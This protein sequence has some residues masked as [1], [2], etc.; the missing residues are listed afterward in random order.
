M[1]PSA[2]QMSVPSV[3]H[4]GG[5][6]LHQRLTKLYS[7]TKQSYE[8]AAE[9][10]ASS[11]PPTATDPDVER[12]CRDFQ[13]QKDRLLA[14]GL[15]W[16]DTN[17]TEAKAS[18]GHE[19]V[20]IDKKL[21]QAGHG[22][23]VADVMSEIQR[24]LAETANM[25]QPR[26]VKRMKRDLKTATHPDTTNDR[27]WSYHEIKEFR[28][29][30]Q[31]LT[32][33]LDVLYSLS[34]S[35]R[36]SS[37]SSKLNREQV[38]D[39]ARSPKGSWDDLA[40]ARLRPQASLE[41]IAHLRQAGLLRDVPK[42]SQ[43]FDDIYFDLTTL[44]LHTSN[45]SSDDLPL[46]E[47]VM[48]HEKSRVLGAL[49]QP[50]KGKHLSVNFR[51]PN[52]LSVSR[53][54][55]DQ[56][57]GS[58]PVFIE[59]VSYAHDPSWAGKIGQGLVRTRHDFADLLPRIHLSHTGHLSFVGFTLD[60]STSRCG[61][62][63]SIQDPPLGYDACHHVVPKSLSSVLSSRTDGNDSIPN[64]EDRFRL[65]Y[66]LTIALASLHFNGKQHGN[67]D[68]TNVVLF[69]PSDQSSVGLSYIRYPYLFSH[70]ELF[71]DSD[72]FSGLL[73][74]SIYR[75]SD[76]TAEPPSGS[77]QR[78]D[79][80]DMSAAHEIYSLGL[81][82]LE[83]GLW[84]PLSKFWKSKY[85]NAVF[86]SRVKHL[87]VPKLASKCGST[88][89]R[90]VMRCLDVPEGCTTAR[91]GGDAVAYAQA[92]LSGLLK[93]MARCCA[94]DV[95]G[96]T[97]R[98]TED[99]AYFESKL[100]HAQPKSG[101]ESL[102]LDVPMTPQSLPDT[103]AQDEL[104]ENSPQLQ[105]APGSEPHSKLQRD[106]SQSHVLRRFPEKQ[107]LQEHI[108]LWHTFLMPRLSKL[109]EKSLARSSTSSISLEMVGR[110]PED[111]RPTVLIECSD[112][113]GVGDMLK[114][115]FKPKRGWGV[116]VIQGGIRRSGKRAS[117]K[118]I[119]NQQSL[120]SAHA[121]PYK[122]TSYQAIPG[123]GASIGAFVNHHHLPPVSFGGTILVDER[124][125]GMTVHHMLDNPSD[126]E[127]SEDDDG[128]FDLD[129]EPT[130]RCAG[131]PRPRAPIKSSSSSVQPSD[132]SQSSSR[133]QPSPELNESDNLPSH[134]RNGEQTDDPLS[135]T[136]QDSSS[137]SSV[138][139]SIFD[140][141]GDSDAST[142]KPDYA[143]LD[144]DGDEFWF[145][146]DAPSVPELGCS[147]SDSDQGD[148]EDL[149]DLA[150]VGDTAGVDPYD[151]ND[152]IPVTQPA[153]DDVD[154][155]FFPNL[156][157]KDD[158]HLSS[159]S[160]GY[161][162]ASS[163]IRRRF[164]DGLKHEIDW[165]LLKI[166]D[167]RLKL[168]NEVVRSDSKH[169]SA[170]S[171]KQPRVPSNQGGAQHLP[172]VAP[173][174]TLADTSVSCHGRTSGLRTGRISR[175]M[176]LVKMYGRETF[177]NSWCVEGG[178]GVP[179]D[180]GAW[181]YNS[182]SLQLCGH[183]LA[184]GSQ[185][186]TAYIAPMEVLFEDIKRTLG[187]ETVRVPVAEYTSKELMQDVGVGSN[188]DSLRAS[189]ISNLNKQLDAS[190]EVELALE[191]MRL[192]SEREQSRGREAPG[193][194]AG[195]LCGGRDMSKRQSLVI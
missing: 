123:S 189:T 32:T 155:D 44:D 149:D 56:S 145:L 42:S 14:W 157:D 172:Y 80:F 118:R 47:D 53:T 37:Y 89:M 195:R 142:I 137:L 141:D 147:D 116:I 76:T 2:P 17:A 101:D 67:F 22:S 51:I 107:A 160:F 50:G 83:I 159:H 52:S 150:S 45:R 79:D 27:T 176:T 70:A 55:T 6:Y 35:R 86:G 40:S 105:E 165:A 38:N 9:T 46:Y 181:I 33:C 184:W 29:R 125:Y 148:D 11:A 132:R 98:Q 24:L 25:Q 168:G 194:L 93:E 34:E 64:L 179:G 182:D 68:S 74:T 60:H 188:P 127:A 69:Q 108:D 71:P 99:V 164:Q 153:I 65:A 115:K 31:Q 7:D 124:P 170:R 128:G 10:T 96:P 109:M 112:V 87:Y 18:G 162:H 111:A 151:D 19:E 82:L 140:E 144:D 173:S 183:V 103:V 175:A 117:R 143:V 133:L 1:P 187:A 156:E 21:D 73:S 177:S 121:K 90:L 146:D 75:H 59:F 186:K 94:L 13:V 169:K 39:A 104:K 88:Y 120:A 48:S 110:S 167:E 119:T 61:L 8:K 161:V 54:G 36:T 106:R 49:R 139:G 135:P 130:T 192:S 100:K 12:L 138:D 171:Q 95:D 114:K 15:Y 43:P 163:G 158:D 134:G 154:D 77:R 26:P 190:R 41:S 180:S 129:S 97:S 191:E 126:D 193:P 23:V 5:N 122:K 152:A 58:T 63:Y 4:R 66:N 84:M 178:F 136:L 16:A 20:N 85:T 102:E 185:S 81:V 30:L 91:D 62:I 28:S 78:L 92:C 166:H 113:T 3:F 72:H 131:P 57:V 174:N